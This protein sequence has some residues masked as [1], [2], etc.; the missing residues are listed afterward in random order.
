MPAHAYKNAPAIKKIMDTAQV[1]PNDIRTQDDL[2]K[3][4]VVSKHKLQQMQQDDPPFGGFLGVPLRQLKR[5]YLSPG[6]IYDPHGF[7]EEVS[8]KTTEQAFTEAGFSAQDI[9]INTFMYH[10]VPAGLLMDEALSQMGAT[11]V[12]LGPGN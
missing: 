11:V 7:S 2:G 4:P 8:A 10:M 12:P 3:I 9:V 1:H 5:I 6:P